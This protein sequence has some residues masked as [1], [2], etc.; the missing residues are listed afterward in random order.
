MTVEEYQICRKKGNDMIF[1]Q[2][3]EELD[4]I[5][6]KM[7][8]VEALIVVKECVENKTPAWFFNRD[9]ENM[10]PS[11]VI[12][13]RKRKLSETLAKLLI[14][15]YEE[16]AEEDLAIAKEF[17]QVENELDETCDK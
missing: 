12:V 8:P 13:F 15:R 16:D 3:F 6:K 10:M 14:E 4:M 7:D 5:T 2:T 9:F 17:E 1:P 11:R